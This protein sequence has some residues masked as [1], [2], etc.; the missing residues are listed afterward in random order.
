MERERECSE[1][2]AIIISHRSVLRDESLSSS[3]WSC[4]A[5]KS[6]PTLFLHPPPQLT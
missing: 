4:N 3:G 1:S 6:F 2:G 5:H